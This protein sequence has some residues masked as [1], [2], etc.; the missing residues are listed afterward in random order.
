MSL[1]KWGFIAIILLPVAEATAFVLV[2]IMIGWLSALCL[3]LATSFVGLLLLRQFGRRGIERLRKGVAAQG[4]YAINLESPGLGPVLGAILLIFPGFIT[5]VAGLLLL[6]PA[7][8]RGLRAALGRV[9]QTRR[10]ER[11]P[12]V[13]DLTPTEWRQVSENSNDDGTTRKRVR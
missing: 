5:D 3:F 13:V 9:A 12:S 6:V 4:V 10:R 11:D 7:V 2:A 8:R 1:V